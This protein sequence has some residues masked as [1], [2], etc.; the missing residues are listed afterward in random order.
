MKNRCLWFVAQINKHKIY[1]TF[2]LS[3]GLQ[4]LYFNTKE[5]KYFIDKHIRLLK[6]RLYDVVVSTEV[7]KSADIQIILSDLSVA[8]RQQ[9]I[10]VSR[11]NVQEQEVVEGHNPSEEELQEQ[12]E[13]ECDSEAN[14]FPE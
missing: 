14:Q 3:Q 13:I 9:A 11:K 8:N 12:E 4:S 2:L 5:R 7:Q 1:I 6:R 10:F